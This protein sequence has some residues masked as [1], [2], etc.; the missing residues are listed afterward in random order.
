MTKMQPAQSEY[1]Q[2]RFGRLVA[3]RLSAGTAEL[4]YSI[5][6]RLR[7]ARVQAVAVR[8]PAGL[9]TATSVVASGAGAVLTALA[10]R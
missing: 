9:R 4:P 5:G 2:D 10:A 3:S 1:L 8:K 7:A 6:E